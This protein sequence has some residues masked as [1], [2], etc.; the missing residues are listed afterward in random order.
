M[1]IMFLIYFNPLGE[2][3]WSKIILINVNQDAE[4]QYLEAEKQPTF[5]TNIVENYFRVLE[6][7]SSLNFQLEFKSKIGIKPN[8]TDLEV[9]ALSLTAEFMS[10]D[11]E[12]SLFK[13]LLLCEMPN[14][15]ERSQFN[16]RRKKLFLFSEQISDS[17]SSFWRL[18]YCW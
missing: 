3:I 10:I 11:S 7:L 17:I 13:Q 18:F 16:K 2:I 8:I 9:I 15:I 6:V 1:L 14:L 4:I 12:N 5:I